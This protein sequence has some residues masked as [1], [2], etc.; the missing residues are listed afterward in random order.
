MKKETL[1]GSFVLGMVFLGVWLTHAFDGAH[2]SLLERV[3]TTTSVY[4]TLI[5]ILLALLTLAVTAYIFLEGSLKG[6]QERY[7]QESVRK[8]LGRY[9]RKLLGLTAACV[10]SLLLCFL[11][12][13]TQ[14]EF[15]QNHFVL[16]IT[17]ALSSVVS[18]FLLVY[19]YYIICYERCL[20][21]FARK[22]RRVLF[23]T[24]FD[25]CL[26]Q[27]SCGK[28]D[29][30]FKWIGD[31]EMLVE[32]LIQNHRDHFHAFDDM[33]VLRSITKEK[34]EEEHDFYK[35]YDRLISYRNFLWVE[36][37]RTEGRFIIDSLEFYRVR[38][39]V[40]S[41][42]EKLGRRLL[43]G[44]RMQEQSF[45]A[46]FLSL[47]ASPLK[48]EHT[49][50]S[51]A[52][53]DKEPVLQ[54]SDRP[55][56][57]DFHKAELRG[58][59][60]THARLNYLNLVGAN[61]T[62]AVFTEAVLNQIQVDAESCF[63]RAVF[64][65]TDFGYQNFC[66]EYGVMC[67]ESASFDNALL[68]DCAFEWC[69]LRRAAFNQAV[70]SNIE[71]RSVCLSYADLREAV[72]TSARLSFCDS[73]NEISRLSW[74]D[75]W[76]A[77]QRG[78]N[79]RPLQAYSDL[80]NGRWL[81]PAF[82]ANLENCVLSQAYISDYNFIGSRISHANFSDARLER[83]ILD[84]CY[85]QKATFQEAVLKDCRF[86]FAMFN[87][88]DL[89]YAHI[90]GCDFSDSDLQDSLLV[91]IK[92]NGKDSRGSRFCRANFTHAQVRGC[93]FQSC[94]FTK[95]LLENADLRDSVFRNCVF[96][97]ASFIGSDLRGA[98]FQDCDLR[99]AGFS[100]LNT[101][102]CKMINCTGWPD[103]SLEKL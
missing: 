97:N 66:A 36:Q 4:A 2:E 69:D 52:V 91:Q 83:C 101:E 103:K 77:S 67:F 46:P 49:V 25:T 38:Q 93:E 75:Y 19:T 32:R 54:E 31:L 11:I 87:L 72:L 80:W 84:R 48:L 43:Q 57:I 15:F 8:L 26:G 95:A 21:R 86:C 61:C 100:G 92:M 9:T 88:V 45:T 29:E 14:I 70:M 71:L 23:P 74:K 81:G 78:E 20:I 85:G 55:S 98:V 28:E 40:Q 94:D 102:T 42:E 37:C 6:R 1:F 44:E 3:T 35:V 47:C 22:S 18:L 51:D 60:F 24:G 10:V 58:A 16:F 65:S 68:V 7:E 13:N 82:F 79:G 99:D 41:L 56:G 59:D 17:A 64:R 53:F 39:A 63:R 76:E 96:L 30:V 12:D 50:F 89:S 62:E 5:T 33:S 34:A 27:E 90:D 73:G